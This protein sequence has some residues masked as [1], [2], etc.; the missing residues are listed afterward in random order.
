MEMGLQ[1]H[2]GATRCW[3]TGIGYGGS[4]TKGW[5]GESQR[6]SLAARGVSTKRKHS[7][8]VSKNVKTRYFDR[9]KYI[10]VSNHRTEKSARKKA[11]SIRGRKYGGGEIHMVR[12]RVTKSC[13]SC[14]QV[15]KHVDR[16]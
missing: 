13:P 10:L 5:R 3:N 8:S 7:P 9:K 11:E 15:W 14:W 6:H 2:D 12:S 1:T 16:L 4:L